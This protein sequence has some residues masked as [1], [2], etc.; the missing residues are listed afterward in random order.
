MSSRAS[1]PT[2]AL[3]SQEQALLDAVRQP[4]K[5]SVRVETGGDGVREVSVEEVHVVTSAGL[6]DA[7]GVV[8]R[9][10]SESPFQDVTLSVRDGRLV[11]LRRVVRSRFPVRP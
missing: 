3:S 7:L 11:S 9:L 4:G 2:Q 1:L 8:S 10:L 6:R 5:R